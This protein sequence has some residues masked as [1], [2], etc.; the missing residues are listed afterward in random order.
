MSITIATLKALLTLDTSDFT[1]NAGKAAAAGEKLKDNL[2]SLGSVGVRGFTAAGTAAAALLGYGVKIAADMEQAKIGF[3]TLLGSAEKADSFIRD[4]QAFAAKTRFEFAGLQESAS[5]LLAVGFEANRVIPLMTVLGDATSAVGT[6]AE[7]IDRAVLAL[8]QMQQKGKVTGEEMLQLVEAG[9]PAW[10]AL[11][12][13]LGIDVA[14]AQDKV[15]KGQVKV[16]DLFD[17]LEG[18]A[19]PA[20]QRVSGMMDKQSASFTGMLSTLKDTFDQQMATLAKPLMEGLK[21]ALPAITEFIDKGVKA[22]TPAVETASRAIGSFFTTLTTGVSENEESRT[23]IE[24]FAL[25]IRGAFQWVIDNKDLVIGTVAAIGVAWAASMALAAAETIAATWPLLLVVG[26]LSAL[27]GVGIRLWGQ[28]GDTIKQKVDEFRPKLEGF[29]NEVIVPF[30][31]FIRDKWNVVWDEARKIWQWF[32]DHLPSLQSAWND[33]YENG[34]KPIFGFISENQEQ[35]KNLAVGIAA[36]IGVLG[37]LAAIVGAA[38]LAI[39]VL[40]GVILVALVAA[41]IVLA[42]VVQRIIQVVWDVF[43]NV[44]DAFGWIID[45]IEEGIQWFWDFANNVRDAFDRAKFEIARFVFAAASMAVSI[46]E[47]INDA[48][49]WFQEL[50]GRILGALGDLG[51]LLYNAGKDLLSGLLRGID[52]AWNWVQDKVRSLAGSLPD[53]VKGPLGIRSPSTVFMKLGS[54]AAEGFALGIA[55]GQSK[56]M[57]ASKGMAAAAQRAFGSADA[58]RELLAQIQRGGKIW[59]DLS[60]SGMSQQYADWLD[61]AGGMANRRA[62]VSSYGTPGVDYGSGSGWDTNAL[63][64]RLDQIANQPQQLTQSVTVRFAGDTSDALATVI[65]GLIRAGKIQLTAGV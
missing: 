40:A 21:K 13:K 30:T 44:R 6:G 28:Y 4:L 35:L 19:G 20:L 50:P 16:N 55:S 32:D 11:A 48:I 54:N 9:I 39:A 27:I 56:V 45:K 12:S 42:I 18:R 63:G 60:F 65:M 58:A 49:R 10:D 53:W 25:A 5:K 37:I 38:A 61:A 36:V 46:G 22:I 31:D 3:T 29:Y 15:S 43:N 2:H 14:T 24:S 26:A 8:T 17:A 64:G 41:V 33:L 62:L 52:T 47:K 59:E 34:L 57:D 7:G 51:G 23:K 1:G